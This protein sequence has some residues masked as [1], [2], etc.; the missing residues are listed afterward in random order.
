MGDSHMRNY[1]IYF[2]K[3]EEEEILSILRNFDGVVI[4]VVTANSI[5]ITIESNIPDTIYL[6]VMDEIDKQV[7]TFRQ[8]HRYQEH[9]SEGD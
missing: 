2:E 7:Y 4:D 8:F 9:N 5:G 3:G 6:K 1:R